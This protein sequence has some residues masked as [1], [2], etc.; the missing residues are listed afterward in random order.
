[1]TATNVD[2]TPGAV[3]TKIT[4]DNPPTC[5]LKFTIIATIAT[6]ERIMTT[7]KPDDTIYDFPSSTNIQLKAVALTA[8]L[9]SD[10]SDIVSVNI[11]PYKQ[12][13]PPPDVKSL[14][15]TG[16]SPK[17]I[18]A[19]WTAPDIVDIV[20]YLISTT[21]VKD[22]QPY[23]QYIA[24]EIGSGSFEIPDL[25]E[26]SWCSSYDSNFV[27]YKVDDAYMVWLTDVRY[28]G[29]DNRQPQHLTLVDAAS[30]PNNT[31]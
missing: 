6:K 7:A 3:L 5:N 9:K 19:L 11:P 16:T 29:A 14:E 23:P 18:T 13:K 26:C 4:S 8:I 31:D 2:G 28:A 30:F 25:T 1:M 10:P 27:S 21:L 20:G 12:G 24:T 22:S 15:L 17:S